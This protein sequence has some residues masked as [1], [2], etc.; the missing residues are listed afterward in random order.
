MK[1]KI[2]N[3]DGF[4]IILLLSKRLQKERIGGGTTSTPVAD[5][6]QTNQSAT[7]SVRQ[8]NER[9]HADRTRGAGHGFRR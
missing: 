1:R 9:V 4:N 2:L 8:C 7:I 6:G 3:C 5:K